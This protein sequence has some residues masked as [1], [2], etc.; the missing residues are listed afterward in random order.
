MLVGILV[1]FYGM[2]LA[3]L[4]SCSGEIEASTKST[5]ELL[6][7]SASQHKEQCK[8]QNNLAVETLGVLK[9]LDR[10]QA[11]VGNYASK[12]LCAINTKLGA[13]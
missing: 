3:G 5:K 9:S 11:V 1:I 8:L 2:L 12:Q 7:Y 6:E 10:N 13:P 4:I